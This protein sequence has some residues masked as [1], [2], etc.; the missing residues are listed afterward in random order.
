MGEKI[1]ARFRGY[2]QVKLEYLSGKYN[3]V[4]YKYLVSGKIQ[5]LFG[6]GWVLNGCR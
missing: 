3:Y 1:G 2:L 5:V 6:I 4:V